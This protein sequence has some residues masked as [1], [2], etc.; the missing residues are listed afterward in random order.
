VVEIEIAG[1]KILGCLL[2]EFINAVITPNDYYS[3]LLLPFIPD[4]YQPLQDASD[5]EKVMS[6]LDFVSGMTDVYALDLFRKINGMG[7]KNKSL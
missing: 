5:Y 3:K 1:F 6:V 2:D 4:Q 7:L